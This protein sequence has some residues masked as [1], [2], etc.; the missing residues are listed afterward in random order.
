M[1]PGNVVE[2]MRKNEQELI[3]W[4]TGNEGEDFSSLT[5]FMTFLKLKTILG[6]EKNR[7]QDR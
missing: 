3:C 7:I 1:G 4:S 6:M 2:G 5:S